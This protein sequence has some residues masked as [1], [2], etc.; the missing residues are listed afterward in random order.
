MSVIDQLGQVIKSGKMRT[1]LERFRSSL[2][3]II[4]PFRNLRTA[5]EC[6]SLP[7]RIF[8]IKISYN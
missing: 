8:V 6:L 2:A 3:S 5:D 1:R 4:D 7:D